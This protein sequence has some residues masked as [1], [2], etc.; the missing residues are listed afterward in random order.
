[1]KLL[2]LALLASTSSAFAAPWNYSCTRQGQVIHGVPYTKVTGNIS[3]D[4]LAATVGYQ[5]SEDSLPPFD[6]GHWVIA[7]GEPS[8][9]ITQKTET[10][11][12][13]EPGTLLLD[14][15]TNLPLSDRVSENYRV[16]ELTVPTNYRDN[17]P[18]H[19]SVAIITSITFDNG[20]RGPEWQT[21]RG[22]IWVDCEFTT[23]PTARVT[24][25]P[26]GL[27]GWETSNY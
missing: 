22:E 25:Q 5:I 6:L 7:N 12:P 26:G 16:V 3:I 11:L 17:P 14:L 15:R 18:A 24:K 9:P 8:L 2:L 20:D 27:R 10:Y 4:L 23:P 13:K 1:M 21:D 19:V